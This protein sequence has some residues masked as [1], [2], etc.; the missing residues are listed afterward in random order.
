MDLQELFHLKFHIPID[1]ILIHPDNIDF[2]KA[3]ASARIAYGDII[4]GIQLLRFRN[5]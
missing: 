4:L 2:L 3:K 1:R 5:L